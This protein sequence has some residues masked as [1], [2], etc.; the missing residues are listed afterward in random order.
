MADNQAPETPPE[1]LPPL[2]TIYF[3]LCSDCNLACRHCW[4]SPKYQQKGTSESALDH[5]LFNDII[6]RAR[7]LGLQRVKLTGGEPLIHPHIIEILKYIQ[8]A[9]LSLTMETNGIAM[10]SEIAGLIHECTKPFCSVSI[11]GIKGTHDSIR[12]VKGSFEQ[13]CRGAEFISG[14]GV[15]LQIIMTVMR[16]NKDE[17]ESVTSLAKDLGAKSI[18][19]NFVQPTERGELMHSRGETLTVPELIDL[20]EWMQNDL[21]KTA[22]ISVFSSLPLAFRP[23]GMMFA[24][25]QGDCGVCGIHSILGVLSNGSYALC[26]IGESINELTFGDAR[27]VDL[28][29]VWSHNPVLKEIREHLPRDLKGVCAECVMKWRCLGSCIAQ[30]Y[31]SSG[32]L[33][34]DFWFCHSAHE[35]GLFPVSRRIPARI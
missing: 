26:G 6:T 29:E 34:S 15:P 27:K 1:T 21:R 12:G 14:A 23:L 10:T 28:V 13:A 4:I 22:G 32:D 17:I 16:F 5:I 20:G 31:Y 18:K 19:F 33:L 2:Q 24:D 7:P 30:N 25:P 9:Q 8:D 3:Y 35:H 11:D